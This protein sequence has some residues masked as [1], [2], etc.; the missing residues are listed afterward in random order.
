[1]ITMKNVEDPAQKDLASEKIFTFSSFGSRSVCRLQ[2]RVP[3]N[4]L[5]LVSE[6][7][8]FLRFALQSK[9][10]IPR[11]NIMIEDVKTAVDRYLT[12]SLT[13][14]LD[15]QSPEFFWLLRGTTRR[16]GMCKKRDGAHPREGQTH[17]PNM[18]STNTA[19][20][21][22]KRR[23]ATQ[24]LKKKSKMIV[25][26]KKA[27]A[28]VTVGGDGGDTGGSGGRGCEG[29]GAESCGE[30]EGEAAAAATGG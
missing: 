20:T 11:K 7:F 17:C 6:E 21:I 12:Y 18:T 22:K 1:M 15:R 23:H 8:G 4:Y 3:R 19:C 28:A 13:R 27:V 2:S 30:A 5:S 26:R 9:Q 25:C 29:G 16:H 10:L 14:T 24:K